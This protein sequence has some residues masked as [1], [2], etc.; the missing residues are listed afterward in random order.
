[1]VRSCRQRAQPDRCEAHTQHSGELR[2][3]RSHLRQP[4]GMARPEGG[5]RAV[6]RQPRCT[7]DEG[8]EPASQAQAPQASWRHREQAGEPHCAEPPAARVRGAGAQPEV[9]CRLHLHLDGRGLALCRSG[10]GP[11]LAPHCGLVDE[12]HHASSNGE[13]CAADG[14]VAKRQTGR[15]DAPFGPGQPGRIQPVV[16]TPGCRTDFMYSFK[17]SAGVFQPSV[18]RGLL[19][20]ARATA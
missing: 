15:A 11:V 20:K 1:M 10:D 16:A 6:R 7:P 9:G 8:G 13:R 4:A 12:R 2:A 14:L 17:V 5:G 3:Q 19:F 18:L